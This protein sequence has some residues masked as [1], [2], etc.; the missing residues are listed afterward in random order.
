MENETFAEYILGEKDWGTKMEIMYYLK[1]KT[2][3]HYNNAVIFKTVITKLFLDYLSANNPEIELDENIVITAR[4]LCDCLK[5]QNSTKRE[6]IKSYATKGAE[7]LS[8][9]GFDERF[10]RICEGVNRYTIKAN[11]PIESD[12]IELAD[13]FGAMLL[14]RPERVGFTP[15]EAIVLL[16]YRNL[17]GKNN[18][19]LPQFKKF[20]NFLQEV[21][22]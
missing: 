11:R 16:E 13:Q 22:V 2:G 1:R 19:L 17:K 15:E 8:S 9:L 7:Y 12:L 21:E 14:D 3:I 20:V 4:L 18:K 5:I 10:C 6:E